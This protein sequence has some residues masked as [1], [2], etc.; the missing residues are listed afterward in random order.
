MNKKYYG[1]FASN[2][3]GVYTNYEKFLNDRKFMR[4]EHMKSFGDREDA[5][6]FALEGFG[7]INGTGCELKGFQDVDG[8]RLNYFYFRKK[9]EVIE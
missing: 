6:D 5:K 3:L 1:V 4:S 2:G 7:G 8:M 9:K